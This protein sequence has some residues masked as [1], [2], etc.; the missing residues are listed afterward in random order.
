MSLIFRPEDQTT[1]D[2]VG[3]KGFH[4]QKLSSWGA[5]VA[6]FLILSTRVHEEYLQ[7]GIPPLVR[8]QILSFLSLYPKLALRSSMTGEDN[9]DA[10]FAGIFETKL[11]VT[12]AT[13][14]TD[15][16]E[17][18]ESIHSQRVKEYISQKKIITSLSMAVVVQEQVDVDCSGVLFTRAPV[19]ITSAIA[20]DAALGMGEGV[21]SGHVEVDHYQLTRLDELIVEKKKEETPVLSKIKR[22]YLLNEA[23]RLE[24]CLG[25]PADIE[26]GFSGEKCFIFQIRPITRQFD[27]LRVLVDTNLSESYP[28]NVSP[29]TAGFVKKAYENVFLESA[30]IL[31]SSKKRLEKLEPHMRQLIACV[32]GHLYY[33]LEHYYA[34]L[35]SLPGG[36]KN[37]ENWHRMI[38]GKIKGISI[39]F[40]STSPSRT[41]SIRSAFS[42]IVMALRKDKIFKRFLSDL[43]KISEEILDKKLTLKSSSE[44][45]YTSEMNSNMSFLAW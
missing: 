43:Q 13:W 30:I 12:E 28:G 26:W 5:Q 25:G 39:P 9:K 16:K 31:G 17:I 2:L 36:E 18:Y 27:P 33:N 34:V 40:H 7:K 35:R 11:N 37:I 3:G 44:S 32:D 38:G 1:I 19:G 10:S 22:T 4:L 29:F 42:L 45:A 23:L 6:P 24:S 20:I 41:E 15:L 14:E 8:L 21:V